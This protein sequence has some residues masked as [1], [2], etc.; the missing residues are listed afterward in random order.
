MDHG[1]CP[2]PS[3]RSVNFLFLPFLFYFA[4]HCLHECTNERAPFLAL[5]NFDTWYYCCF[6]ELLACICS[7]CEFFPDSQ[8]PSPLLRS[9]LPLGV[10]ETSQTGL[11]NNSS[12]QKPPLF[13]DLSAPQSSPPANHH[14]SAHSTSTTCLKPSSSPCSSQVQVLTLS[15]IP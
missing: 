3:R 9:H 10:R 1:I 11:P 12:N 5:H 15:A 8:E 6:N 2:T 7:V 13:F 4:F 14:V